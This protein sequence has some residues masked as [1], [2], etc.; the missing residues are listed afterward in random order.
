[1][2]MAS[3]AEVLSVGAVLPFLGVLTQPDRIFAHPAIQPVLAW[4]RIDTPHDLLL[5]VTVLFVAAILWA[6]GMRLLLLY[7]S[8]KLSYA[9][10]ADFSYQIY[11][12]TLFQPYAVHVSRHSSEIISSV[13]NKVG[14][15]ITGLMMPVLTLIS[16][17]FILIA[18]LV[19]LF[20]V[21]PW[22]SLATFVGLGVIYGG[23]VLMTR[24]RLS[25]YSSRISEEAV[26]VVKVLQEG[27]G[28]IR[29]VLIDGAQEIYCR[30][31]QQADIPL[32]HAQANSTIIGLSPR[33]AVEAL[34]MVFIAVLAYVMAQREGGIANTITLLGALA[35]GAQRLLPVDRKSVV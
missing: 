1:M 20:A 6:G 29:D 3:F 33:F 12:R 35:L 15:I 24:G 5:P 25:L 18:I 21:D 28:G 17:V 34:G 27:L 16:S 11:R 23:I 13:T 9:I 14:L 30:Q 7:V 8:T 10:G 4:L 2:V 31:Y 26:R 22:M 32:R 19:A